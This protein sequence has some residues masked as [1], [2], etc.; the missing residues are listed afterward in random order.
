MKKS[1]KRALAGILAAAMALLAAGC[2]SA[3]SGDTSG[4][5]TD[6][7]SIGVI[8]YATHASLDNCYEGLLKGLADEGFVE[9]ENL[10]IDF[11]N[12]Q[13]E[14]STADT[15]A[16]TMAAKQYDMICA[17]AT[18]AAVSAYAATK[19]DGTPVVFTAVND[20]VASQLVNSLEQPGTTCT[21]S[22]DVLPLESQLEMIRAFLPDATKI[23]VLYT[24]SES[25][26]I[27][28]LQRFKELAPQYGFEVVE[29]GVTNSSE[30]A[31]GAQALAAKGVDCFNNFTDNNVVN[32]LT[33]EL[34]AAQEANIPVFGSEIEQVKNGCLASVSIDF[35]ALGE[36]TGKIAG[37]ILKG[38]ASPADTPVYTVEDGTPVYNPDVM[39]QLGLTLPETF[40]DAQAVTADSE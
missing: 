31:T 8:Q 26:S 40:Q 35:V 9:G 23:G 25:N 12:A 33:S 37:K 27:S 7:K 15:Q 13:G 17:I 14:A 19:A 38:E 18:P 30:V 29:Q 32:N 16:Q 1:C 36:E 10:T 2:D 4:N 24:T 5:A 21:G 34:Q 28:V 39:E 3:S 11:Q 22:S 20:P 6:S